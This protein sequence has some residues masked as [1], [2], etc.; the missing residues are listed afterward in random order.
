ML[1]REQPA[2]IATFL[3]SLEIQDEPSKDQAVGEV[4]ST[5][6]TNPVSVM[7]HRGKK[8]AQLNP[9]SQLS[10][11]GENQLQK[12]LFQPGMGRHTKLAKR[13]KTLRFCPAKIEKKL[14]LHWR[15]AS[16]GVNGCSMLLRIVVT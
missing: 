8:E 12:I 10:C 2:A 3:C 15:D 6:S 11:L 13:E 14:H 1:S 4:H 9:K 7:G 16:Q 5:V